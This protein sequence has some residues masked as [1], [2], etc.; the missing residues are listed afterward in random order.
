M[1]GQ[2]V[3]DPGQ[4]HDLGRGVIISVAASSRRRRFC[5]FLITF[6]TMKTA[7]R[8]Q[9]DVHDGGEEAA[10]G[11]VERDRGEVKLADRRCDDL[12]EDIVSERLH[13]YAEGGS[14]HD[15]QSQLGGVAAINE[16]L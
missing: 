10:I 2:E 6:T 5:R 14:E 3:A 1:G 16:V 12:P 13:D 8:D 4:E 7:K 11:E 9:Q 15:S